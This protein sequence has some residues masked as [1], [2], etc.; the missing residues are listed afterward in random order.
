MTSFVLN[1]LSSLLVVLI[2][3]TVR[4]VWEHRAK[5]LAFSRTVREELGDL[6]YDVYC[7]LFNPGRKGRN[8]TATLNAQVVGRIRAAHNPYSGEWE[9]S[10]VNFDKD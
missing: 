8:E 10:R 1:V 4:F 3:A 5:L 2:L 7:L 6:Y 9:T